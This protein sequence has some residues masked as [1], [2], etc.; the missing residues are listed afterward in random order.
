M[1]AIW[2]TVLVIYGVGSILGRVRVSDSR[3]T[4]VYFGCGLLLLA[5]SIVLLTWK[6]PHGTLSQTPFCTVQ[7]PTS[8]CT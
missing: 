2:F 3:R 7:N 5:I 4:Q 8:V 6:F 1:A